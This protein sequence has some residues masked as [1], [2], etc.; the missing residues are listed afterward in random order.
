MNLK[1]RN[2]IKN[3][4]CKKLME[5]YKYFDTSENGVTTGEKKGLPCPSTQ[6]FEDN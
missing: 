1:I 3:R 2:T 6:R 4:P 5:L